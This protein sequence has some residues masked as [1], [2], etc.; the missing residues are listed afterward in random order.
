[1]ALP[2]G[3]DLAFA[4]GHPTLVRVERL[5]LAG[6]GIVL[7]AALALMIT[8][9][10]QE[11]ADPIHATKNW[12]ALWLALFALSALWQFTFVKRLLRFST[13][14][15]L[16]YGLLLLA[17]LA[18]AAMIV[19]SDLYLS[20]EFHHTY[21]AD[22]NFRSTFAVLLAALLFAVFQL[23]QSI[24]VQARSGGSL[25]LG[26]VQ[27]IAYRSG[28]VT[29]L[30]A[31]I[32]GI[33]TATA[34]ITVI[35]DDYARYWTIADALSGGWG[36]PASEV[37]ATYQ[38]GGMAAYLVDLP[39]LPLAMLASF[40]LLG[41][42]VLAAMMPT[43][44]VGSLFTVI[45]FLALRALTRSAPLSFAVATALTLFPLLT[46]YVLRAGEPDGMFVTL[47]MAL[48][49]LAIEG[50]TRGYALSP[51]LTLGVVAA[52]VALTRPEGIMYAGITFLT[53]FLR[54]RAGRG[55]WVATAAFVGLLI[56]FSIT[57]L[58]TF[59]S[60]WPTTFAGTV[61]VGHIA[62]NIDGF[63]HWGLPRYSAALG[64]PQSVVLFL[65]C[66]IIALYLVGA[67]LIAREKPQLLFLALLP[68]L[69]ALSFLLV[70]PALTRPQFPYDYFRRA[71]Y[72]LP[73]LTMVASYP[74]AL[75]LRGRQRG[76]TKSI[77]SLL[78]V[79][80]SIATIS[81]EAK[82]GAKPE[83]IY[84]GGTQILTS[85]TYIMATDLLANPFPMPRMPFEWDGHAVVVA[86]SFDY[87][88]FRTKLNAAFAPV[89]LHGSDRATPYVSTSL[90]LFIV[91]ML[92]ALADRRPTYS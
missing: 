37:G 88:D 17:L 49:L 43:L 11:R 58:A 74:I 53:L 64:L 65:G 57:M 72:G 13:V 35:G 77:V 36:Y 16:H 14:K 39:G 7:S 5:A 69:N 67:W 59:H 45:S 91:G 28:I 21:T 83:E 15:P 71:S 32:I 92:Y 48:A 6:L 27:E 78:L 42:N 2:D 26:L 81:Y 68:A 29:I 87:M 38:A 54:H 31:T 30:A 62:Q 75:G 55:F 44:V 24:V 70:S 34:Y 66:A 86:S 84:E 19:D 22:P 41:H 46:F 12:L 25:L 33:L 52:L 85:G 51:W 61:Q 9:F 23:Q 10:F 3:P 89:D 4:P 40:A 90:A 1:M 60:P 79:M 73:F 18:I 63:V 50:D 47:L 20:D 56:P 80:L 82:L 8:V 76:V